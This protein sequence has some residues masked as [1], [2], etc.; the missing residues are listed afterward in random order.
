MR[1]LRFPLLALLLALS[2]VSVAQ[3]NFFLGFQMASGRGQFRQVTE[4]EGLMGY[5]LQGGFMT[6][7][8]ELPLRVGG[9]LNW[10][11]TGRSEHTGFNGDGELVD[12]VTVNNIWSLQPWLRIQP[13][14]N[15]PVQ[16]F[17][18]VT[19]GAQMFLTKTKIEDK[20]DVGSDST[21]TLDWDVSFALNY[22]VEG[23][24]SV[25]GESA[26]VE[27]RVIYL[28]GGNVQFIKPESANINAAGDAEYER[29]ETETDRWLYQINLVIPL[30]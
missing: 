26:R 30:D 22:G 12:V 5:G 1:T 20:D 6:S 17:F 29:E 27:L 25:G 3:Q 7:L 2:S 13:P 28:N 10:L 15:F 11:R 14:G 18:G 8:G 19:T 9:E 24:L 21:R 4:T 23:G 16:P